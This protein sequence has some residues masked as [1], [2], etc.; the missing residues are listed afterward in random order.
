MLARSAVNAA[1]S[2]GSRIGSARPASMREKS[3]R[4]LTSFCRRSALRNTT[5][6]RSS[7]SSSAA[8]ASASSAGPRISDSGVRNSW[9]T[10]EKKS[11]FARSSSA[12]ACAR[13]RSASRARTLARLAAIWP[14]SSSMKPR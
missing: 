12:S 11:V 3:S 10:L 2:V 14:A 1:R 9:L 7:C 5:D 6:R 4:L 13:R 8:T